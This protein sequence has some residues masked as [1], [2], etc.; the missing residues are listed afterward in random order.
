M[1]LSEIFCLVIITADL[2]LLMLLILYL[3]KCDCYAYNFA[4]QEI[5]VPVGL[6]VPRAVHL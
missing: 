1:N 2:L 5:A 4:R 3:Q 6:G